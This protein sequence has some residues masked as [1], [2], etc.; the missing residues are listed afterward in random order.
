[1]LYNLKSL[2]IV[3]LF[4]SSFSVSAQTHQ[5]NDDQIEEFKKELDLSDAQ[6]LKI[7]SIKEKY[8]PEKAELKRKLKE[9]RNKE[10]TEI[11]KLF[12]PEQKT[13]LKALIERHKA[14]KKAL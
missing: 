10:I 4:I 9:L 6:V 7:K 8:S 1:M 11:D 13:K 5:K 14:Q 2:F 12:T 3:A